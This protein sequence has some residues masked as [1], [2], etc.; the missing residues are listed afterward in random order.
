MA[1]LGSNEN[2]AALSA[3]AGGLGFI[4]DRETVDPLLAMLR[5]ERIAKLGRAFVAAAL[6]GIADKDLLPWNTVLSENAN[7]QAR[8]DTFHNGST[9]VLDI[10]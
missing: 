3:V 10:L 9:G 7:Y 5:N 1:L 4:G 8:V 2:V 6:G